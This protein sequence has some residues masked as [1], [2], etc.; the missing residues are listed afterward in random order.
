VCSG[1]GRGKIQLVRVAGGEKGRRLKEDAVRRRGLNYRKEEN[2]IWNRQYEL[3][4]EERGGG[5]GA[6]SKDQERGRKKRWIRIPPGITK[7]K[8]LTST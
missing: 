8:S 5:Y 4:E 1:R 3:V 6:S 2:T 7:G